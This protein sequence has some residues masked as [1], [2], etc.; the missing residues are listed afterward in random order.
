MRIERVRFAPVA[1]ETRRPMRTVISTTHTPNALVEITADGSPPGRH[2]LFSDTGP[3]TPLREADLC[4]PT[5]A[6]PMRDLDVRPS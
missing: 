2:D 4:A 6:S 3:L 5:T 1:V